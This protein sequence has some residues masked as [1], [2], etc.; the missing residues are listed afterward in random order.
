M[1]GGL[2]GLK[3]R[4]SSPDRIEPAHDNRRRP[5]K[6][7]GESSWRLNRGAR[8]RCDADEAFSG[9]RG[10]FGVDGP[11]SDVVGEREREASLQFGEVGG[12]IERETDHLIEG[13]PEP[14]D[15]ARDG[16]FPGASE[17]DLGLGRLGGFSKNTP[18]LR[19]AV[20]GDVLGG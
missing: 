5:T 18:E 7:A 6:G 9:G 20:D 8:E 10:A 4:E 13:S 1:A 11:E 19:P 14:L 17:A 12:R 15:E 2:R 16:G 3:V